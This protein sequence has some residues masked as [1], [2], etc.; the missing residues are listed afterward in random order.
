V[1]RS[2]RMREPTQVA[3]VVHGAHGGRRHR[4]AAARLPLRRRRGRRTVPSRHPSRTCRR[5]S[6][7]RRFGHRRPLRRRGHC[8]D[9]GRHLGPARRRRRVGRG[10]R[11]SDGRRRGRCRHGCSRRG[12][13]VTRRRGRRRRGRR[14]GLGRRR[15]RNAGRQE[16]ERVEI[17]LLVGR[18]PDPE[19]DVRGLH[20]G[21]A[22]R[23]D[24]ADRVALGDRC[25]LGDDDRTEVREGDRI[26]VGG[27]DG[28]AL[29]GGRHGSRERDRAA[30]RRDNGCARIAGE[31]DAAVLPRGVRM[32]RIEGK[33]LHDRACRGP[34]PRSCGRDEKQRRQHGSRNHVS[35]RHLPRS[36]VVR[37]ENV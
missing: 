23:A 17:T 12:G 36:L 2:T 20:L 11:A 1:R 30:L 8:R 33:R 4:N 31:V 32:G 22:A 9:G 24:R 37:S 29:A 21:I 28:D 25:T 3:R 13:R 15:S 6:R 14:H 27:E 26:A 34:G 19:V 5:R 35:H 16:P 18:D 7:L 10:G